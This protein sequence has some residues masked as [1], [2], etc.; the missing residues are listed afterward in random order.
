MK[1]VLTICLIALVALLI[2]CFSSCAQDRIAG[3]Q[4][5]RGE[6]GPQGERGADGKD[7]VG[8]KGVAAVDGEIII[9]YTD[10][11]TES[12]GRVSDLVKTD[13]LNYYPLDDGTYAV[14]GGKSIYLSDIVIPGEYNGRPVTVIADNGFVECQNLKSITL[15]DTIKVI[16]KNAFWT[17][18]LRNINIPNGIQTI[19]EDAF[20]GCVNLNCNEDGGAKYLGNAENPYLVLIGAKGTEIDSLTVNEKTRIIYNRAFRNS[21]LTEIVIGENI[22]QIGK[23]AFGGSTALKSL[24]LPSL[25]K[26]N[27]MGHIGYFFGGSSFSEN[28]TKLPSSLKYVTILDADEIKDNAFNSCRYIEEV[29]LP[30]TVKRIGEK[31]F[32]NCTNLKGFKIPTGVLEIGPYAF[33]N[34]LRITEIKIPEGVTAIS[35]NTFRACV[36]LES[37]ELPKDLTSIGYAAFYGC[38][39]LNRIYIPKSVE[40]IENDAF[41]GCEALGIYCEAEKRP[42]GWNID[43]NYSGCPVVWG[44]NS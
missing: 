20:L 16:G 22:E 1:R 29:V 9:T 42:R 3:P 18:D 35:E 14:D 33:F 24:T 4:G 15:P 10:G 5:E 32:Y 38:K 39:A 8:V 23:N 34:C 19:G 37:V 13:A 41:R 17:C 12:L 40:R 11:R 44:W 36:R 25:N 26:G 30:T 31:A 7:G 28:A 27:P 6:A 43:W 2:I 21:K